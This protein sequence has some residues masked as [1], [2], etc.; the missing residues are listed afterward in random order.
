ML[1]THFPQ[2]GIPIT[3]YNGLIFSGVTGRDYTQFQFS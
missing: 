3:A 2:M 1:L